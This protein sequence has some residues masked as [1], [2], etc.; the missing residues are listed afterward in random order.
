MTMNVKEFAQSW[1]NLTPKAKVAV[2][3]GVAGDVAMWTGI[4]LFLVAPVKVAV[5]VGVA[6]A[7]MFVGSMGACMYLDAT[8]QSIKK[9]PADVPAGSKTVE[10]K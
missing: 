3:T 8:G 7:A 1:K 5:G 2:G 9:S 4:G 6:G 10:G